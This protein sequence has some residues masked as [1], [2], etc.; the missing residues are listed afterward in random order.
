MKAKL[1]KEFLN[2]MIKNP[3]NWKGPFYFNRK[4]PRVVVPKLEPLKGWTLNCTQPYTYIALVGIILIIVAL[5]YF[6]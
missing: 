3:T 1:N 2:L 6:L 4:D 5:K